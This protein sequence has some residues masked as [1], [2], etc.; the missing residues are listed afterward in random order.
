MLRAAP[1]P[2]WARRFGLD[3]ST[4]SLDAG[5]PGP[6]WGVPR[7][8]ESCLAAQV[9]LAAVLPPAGS[10]SRGES[11]CALL[12][13]RLTA[14]FPRHPW[15]CR[16]PTMAGDDEAAGRRLE[17]AGEQPPL[18]ERRCL[19]KPRLSCGEKSPARTVPAFRLTRPFI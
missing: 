9:S 6:F 15:P 8:R 19:R 17:D 4:L 18:G 7:R 16:S 11:Q 1:F 5:L 10:D 2:C 14:R 12:Q 3:R 13:P